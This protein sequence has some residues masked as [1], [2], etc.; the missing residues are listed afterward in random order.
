MRRLLIW[1]ASVAALLAT[2]CSS[3]PPASSAIVN[4]SDAPS[5]IEALRFTD[6]RCTGKI[7]T[8]S[9]LGAVAN[10]QPI[11]SEPGAALSAA[12]YPDAATAEAQFK[13]NCSEPGY[14]FYRKGEN[15]RAAISTSKPPFPRAKALAI[16]KALS[17]D[18]YYRCQLA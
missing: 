14:Y 12:A 8:F 7:H 6:L 9:N 1:S 18:A 13:A 4:H 16:A 2:A 15:W 10:C 3:A 17:T 11:A 5:V